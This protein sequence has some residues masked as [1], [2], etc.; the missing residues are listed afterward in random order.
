M[1]SAKH[2]MPLFA[3]R[4]KRMPHPTVLDDKGI[5]GVE[6][7]RDAQDNLWVNQA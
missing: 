7:R 4:V 5:V 1:L 6:K 2:Y 3:Q